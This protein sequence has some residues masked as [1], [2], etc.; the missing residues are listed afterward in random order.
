MLRRL[1]AFT[2][3][4]AGVTT[5]VTLALAAPALAKGPSQ[6]SLTGPGLARP[7]VV[8]GNGEPGQPGSALAS[9][10]QQTGL[11]MAMFGTGVSMPGPH[12]LVTPP[13]RSSRGP[14]YTV[15]YTVPGVQPQ[16]GQE[17]GR[18]RQFL[19]PRAADGPVIDTPPG[20]H[21][22]GQGHLP[23]TGWFRGSDRLARTLA[24][25]G[26]PPRPGTAPAASASP[27]SVASARAA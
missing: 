4:T 12:R 5:A 13:R 9:L 2:A 3:L 11:F 27:A 23:V 19:Y 20:Q 6:A 21:G 7:V 22:F 10:A 8:S 18:V 1:I 25:L 16:P 15:V 26:I 17:F 24:R 14:R